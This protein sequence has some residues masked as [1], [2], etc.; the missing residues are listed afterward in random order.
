[1]RLTE[2]KKPMDHCRA[3][4]GKRAMQIAAFTLI[5]CFFFVSISQA[6]DIEKT[7]PALGNQTALGSASAQVRIVEFSDFQCSFCKKFWAD[8]LPRLKKA[9]SK[10]GKCSLAIATLPSWEN[11][12][13]RRPTPPNVQ[14]SKENSG[15]ITTFCL[16]TKAGWLLPI[17]NSSSMPGN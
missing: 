5:G 12:P 15:N 9:T 6:A 14:G 7:L 16:P 4:Y 13:S 8:T 11:F 2:R 10:R 3:H 1:M 17:L